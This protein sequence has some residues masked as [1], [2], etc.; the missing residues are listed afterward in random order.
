MLIIFRPSEAKTGSPYFL[1]NTGKQS[2]WRLVYVCVLLRGTEIWDT[3]TGGAVYISFVLIYFSPASDTVIV[4]R[5]YNCHIQG[6]VVSHAIIRCLFNKWKSMWPKV[7]M[8]IIWYWHI[9]MLTYKANLSDCAYTHT[10]I[11]P[12][13]QSGYHIFAYKDK[14]KYSRAYL[15]GWPMCSRH[16]QNEY[17]QTKGQ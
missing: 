16:H 17:R 12:C 3:D 14:L 9:H 13:V 10:Y 11:S 8:C 5:N 4:T 2:T 1:C 7:F 15:V 6:E